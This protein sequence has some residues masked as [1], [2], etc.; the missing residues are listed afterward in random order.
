VPGRRLIGSIAAGCGLGKGRPGV[1]WTRSVEN[2]CGACRDW[3]R[4]SRAVRWNRAGPGPG[5]WSWSMSRMARRLSTVLESR[6]RSSVVSSRRA[7]AVI[8]STGRDW[9]QTCATEAMPSSRWRT[10]A[11]E[12]F[13]R[14]V[15]RQARTSKIPRSLT[16]IRDRE[17]GRQFRADRFPSCGIENS[18]QKIYDRPFHHGEGDVQ[19]QEAFA[20]FGFA[21]QNADGLIGPKSVDQPLDLGAGRL[22][23]CTGRMFII[24]WGF[25]GR[26]QRPRRRAVRRSIGV[27]GARRRPRVRGPC[28]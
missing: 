20:A 7:G 21:A 14:E 5:G 13:R 1:L 16:A 27:P 17:E 8:T 22:A 10:T 23:C 25:W 9:K 2:L 11:R 6:W 12:S 3:N 18:N 26:G 24:V 4:P 19:G 15:Q 28:S